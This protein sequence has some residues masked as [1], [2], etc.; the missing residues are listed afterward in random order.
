MSAASREFL[1]M[2]MN[3]ETQEYFVPTM[4]KKDIVAKAK[5]D[6]KAILDQGDK[7][8]ASVYMDAVRMTEYLSEFTKVLK[9][10]ITEDEYGKTYELKNASISFRNSGDRLDYDADLVYASIKERLKERE[11]L[12]KLATKSKDMIFDSKGVEVGRVPVKT[13]GTD[14]VV[15]KF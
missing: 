9:A 13:F 7:D 12:L 6:A 15:V 8:T 2:R 14:S 10:N 1:L 5:D 3:E 11:A 4:S